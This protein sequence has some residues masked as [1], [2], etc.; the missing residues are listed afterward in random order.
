MPW[1]QSK[2]PARTSPGAGL[3]KAIIL[4]EHLGTKEQLGSPQRGPCVVG[5]EPVRLAPASTRTDAPFGITLAVRQ[6]TAIPI[7]PAPSEWSA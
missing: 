2:G 7:R 4:K 1:A 3:G 5:Q 6:E